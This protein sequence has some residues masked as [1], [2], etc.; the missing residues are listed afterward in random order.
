MDGKSYY[1]LSQAKIARLQAQQLIPTP[2]PAYHISWDEYLL[3]YSLWII[4]IGLA[5]GAILKRLFGKLRPF[6]AAG[7][8]PVLGPPVV[9]TEHDRWLSAELG[10]H[11]TIGEHLQHQACVTDIEPGTMTK[12]R[13]WYYVGLTDRRL[14]F[15]ETKL[16]F[17]LG[18]TREITAQSERARQEVRAV[19]S[20]GLAISFDCTDEAGLHFWVI[21]SQRRFTNQW[22]FARDVPRLLAHELARRAA[23]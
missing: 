12:G 22:L 4:L 7:T 16:G 11:L 10:K 17:F 23:G 18:P 6:M 19:R 9:R 15:L 3:G 1:S 20:D 2:L 21:A 5:V 13:K 14:L 8:A